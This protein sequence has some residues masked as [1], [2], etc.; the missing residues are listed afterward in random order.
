MTQ[1]QCKHTDAYGVP[2]EIGD[3][4]IGLRSNAGSRAST[5]VGIVHSWCATGPRLT[6]LTD[7]YWR[8]NVRQEPVYFS[9]C[10]VFR[11]GQKAYRER[12]SL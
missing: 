5:V 12:F 11:V 9:S 7:D 4:V 3:V 10:F 6:L 8:R 2:I 1:K